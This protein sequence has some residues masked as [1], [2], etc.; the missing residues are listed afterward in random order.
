MVPTYSLAACPP[1]VP[2]YLPPSRPYLMSLSGQ[3]LF[4]T[5][6]IADL[7]GPYIVKRP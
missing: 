4:P 7:L 2:S 5:L 6:F 3:Y 1:V